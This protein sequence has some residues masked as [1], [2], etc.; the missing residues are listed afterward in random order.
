M[1]EKAK[2]KQLDDGLGWAI[3]L[4]VAP[5]LGHLAHASIKGIGWIQLTVK[6]RVVGLSA[7]QVP[8]VVLG[9]LL[10]AD[11]IE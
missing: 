3:Q 6:R 8:H 10:G 1:R 5:V 11:A 2:D 4:V 7:I 9:G